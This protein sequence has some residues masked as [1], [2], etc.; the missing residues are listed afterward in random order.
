MTSFEIFPRPYEHD[1]VHSVADF[2]GNL[3]R[4]YDTEFLNFKTLPWRL[5]HASLIQKLEA[6]ESDKKSRDKDY[7]TY[8]DK[9]KSGQ[10][11]GQVILAGG[12]VVNA[13]H[14]KKL[15]EEEDSKSDLDF[16]V[17]GE[18]DTAQSIMAKLLAIHLSECAKDQILF[19]KKANLIMVKIKDYS[20]MVQIVSLPNVKLPIHVI[21]DFDQTC[22]QFAYN[23]ENVIA[24]D[25]GWKSLSFGQNKANFNLFMKLNYYNPD[26]TLANFSRRILKW[27][28]R[29]YN[30]INLKELNLDLPKMVELCKNNPNLQ[31]NNCNHVFSTL[32]FG[33]DNS[34]SNSKLCKDYLFDD[35][36]MKV[37]YLNTITFRG[38]R[39]SGIKS[40]N[41]S[42]QNEFEIVICK[43]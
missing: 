31:M 25:E 22:C 41:N 10:S 40:H 11:I 24:T 3:E 2:L 23:G 17:I 42:M 29:G 8:I 15:K 4:R 13:I 19:V 21:A 43:K 33:L 1:S 32:K 12:S 7:K 34:K 16:F 26:K 9:M 28:N 30:T 6:Y 38:D 39:T 36:V 20:R 14:I 35:C 37:Q 5:P 27:N 18:D